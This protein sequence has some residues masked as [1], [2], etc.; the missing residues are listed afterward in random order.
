MA[1]CALVYRDIAKANLTAS[2]VSIITAQFFFSFQRGRVNCNVI[3]PPSYLFPE[4][5]QTIATENKILL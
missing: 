4:L 5:L 1:A 3:K 2:E